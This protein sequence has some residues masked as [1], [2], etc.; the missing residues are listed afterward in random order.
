MDIDFAAILLSALRVLGIGLVLGAGLPAIVAI[1]MHLQARGAGDVTV[2]A[3]GAVTAS[4]PRNPALSALAIV[5]FAFVICA[6]IAGVLFITRHSL[7]HY[8]G[9]TLFGG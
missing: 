2:D 1:A 3:S 7:H 5:L 4:G 6:V 9:I 8:F